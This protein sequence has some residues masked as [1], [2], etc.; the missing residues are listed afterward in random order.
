MLESS[1]DGSLRLVHVDLAG[2][3][4]T[5]DQVLTSRFSGVYPDGLLVGVVTGVRTGEPGLALELA[6]EPSVDF[7]RLGELLILL[8]AD[9][10]GPPVQ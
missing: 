5:G 2:G 4:T 8:P 3:A 1:A 6:V 10:P 9:D 7:S